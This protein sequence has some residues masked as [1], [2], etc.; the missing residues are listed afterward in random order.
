MRMKSSWMNLQLVGIVAHSDMKV[1]LALSSSLQKRSW[2]TE[3][4][5]IEKDLLIKGQIMAHTYRSEGSCRSTE[6][7]HFP[8]AH[9][10]EYTTYLHHG[11]KICKTTF[12]FLHNI[13]SFVFKS[14]KTSCRKDG[15]QGRVHG[16]SKRLPPNTLTLADIQNVTTFIAS[17]QVVLACS[18][19]ALRSY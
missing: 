7:R 3:L 19:V 1:V 4:T 8:Q 12:L 5:R 10:C 17:Y 9:Q 11:L 14:L 15:L 6:Y 2:C 18:E 16:N 13:G